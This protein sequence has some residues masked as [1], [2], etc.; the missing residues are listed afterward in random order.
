M[1]IMSQTIAARKYKSERET[2]LKRKR[3]GDIVKEGEYNENVMA[4]FAK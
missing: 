3:T 2:S 1:N 4:A